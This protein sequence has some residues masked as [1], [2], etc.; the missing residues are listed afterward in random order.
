MSGETVSQYQERLKAERE[1]GIG[2]FRQGFQ[3]ALEDFSRRHPL[4]KKEELN[5]FLATFKQ[6]EWQKAM[7]KLDLKLDAAQE[8]LKKVA[9][10]QSEKE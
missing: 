9:E 8:I 10:G 6:G 4:P 1:K 3:Q 5:S 2:A 7:Y